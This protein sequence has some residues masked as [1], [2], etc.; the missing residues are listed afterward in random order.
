M[1]AVEKTS[2]NDFEASRTK[3]ENLI[4]TVNVLIREIQKLDE[5]ISGANIAIIKSQIL[6]YIKP[7]KSMSTDLNQFC[8]MDSSLMECAGNFE[9]A[10]LITDSTITNYLVCPNF[11]HSY[12]SQKVEQELQGLTKAVLEGLQI[13]KVHITSIEVNFFAEKSCCSR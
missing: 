10:I 3:L 2:D 7:I 11:I 6:G 12:T 8:A 9:N 1:G 5:E 13:V 4:K